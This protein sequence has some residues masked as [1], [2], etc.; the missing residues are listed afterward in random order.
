MFYVRS[1]VSLVFS[2]ILLVSG[3][4]L[5][6]GGEAI[7][8]Q[9]APVSGS[10]NDAKRIILNGLPMSLFSTNRE[11]LISLAGGSLT[12]HAA[13]KNRLIQSEEGRQLLGYVMKCALGWDDVLSASYQ[14][15]TYLFDG[16]VGLATNWKDRALTA[17]EKRWVSACLLAHSNA[18]GEKV[19]LSLR[20]NH[21]ALATTPE[22]IKNYPVE[23]GAFYGD[24]FQASGSAAPMF[25]CSGLG[26][27]DVCELESNEWLDVRVCAQGA[28]S[29]SQ[30]GFYVPGD[31]YDFA[32]ASPGACSEI[33]GDGY[34]ACGPTFGSESATSYDEVI[35]VYL[36]RSA[37]SSCGSEG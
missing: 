29:V 25:A 26:S 36:Q 28:G 2:P 12:S 13:A 6:A 5:P 4:S 31:C 16:G 22:E 19:P 27:K 20:G 21:P 23:E 30:C 10:P 8:E 15:S 32:S 37:G 35:T 17:T 11:S 24:L 9:E 14:G 3:C 33:E 34:G 7:G 1:L 18:F